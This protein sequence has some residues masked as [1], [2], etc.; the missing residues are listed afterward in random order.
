MTRRILNLLEL[1][2][3]LAYLAV[4][5]MA[6][7]LAAYVRFESGLFSYVPTDSTFSYV[8]WVFVVTLV[9]T[10]AVKQI[11]LNKVTT[12][13][14]LRTGITVATKAISYTVVVVLA[15]L[16]FDRHVQFSRVFVSLGCVLMFVL[17]LLVL[18]CFRMIVFSRWGLFKQRLRIAII[19]ADDYAARIAHHLESNPLHAVE[20]ACF[21]SVNGESPAVGNR[22]VL[23][24]TRVA[25]IVDT[26]HC[27]EV[28]IALPLDR[29]NKLTEVLDK[30]RHFCV[31]VRVVLGVDEGFF[32]PERIFSFYGLPLVDMCPYPIDTIG[33]AVGK[34][35]FDIAFS[36]A[37]LL[38]AAPVMAV[39]AAAIKLTSPG[40]IL[41]SQERIGLNGKRFKMFK[42]RTMRVQDSNISDT[43]HTIRNDPRVTRLGKVLRRVS[44]DECPQF[45]NVLKGDMSVVGPRPE[46]TFYM[47]KFRREIPTYMAR[48][49]V[50][51]G[52]TGMAQIK[53]L[54][55][56][57]TSIS[58]RIEHD[59]YYLQNWSMI[60]D[61]KIIL[62][63]VFKGLASK[64]AY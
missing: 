29:F 8:V 27:G 25:E 14:T 54:R 7:G 30:L 4:P 37:V 62:Q 63:T 6:F 64:N 3:S 21:V 1:G 59:L 43:Q 46:L 26:F 56:S 49:N 19:G 2:F 31:P 39:I 13:T 40:P 53:G 11:G 15:L 33:Y 18:F 35:I 9:W 17:S 47:E 5:I 34:R 44:L 52:I 32:V 45:L 55:G 58:R 57:D 41:F 23:D 20:V 24:S 61:F 60:L 22:T 50:K 10:L 42:F 16:F 51:C 48:H 28:L 12:I 36:A 38:I